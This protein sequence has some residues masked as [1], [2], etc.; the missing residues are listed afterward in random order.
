[1]SELS[2]DDRIKLQR[3]CV[4]EHIGSENEGNWPAVY[5]TFVDSGHA[6]YDVMPLST[7]FFGRD[8]VQ[9]FYEYLQSALPDIHFDVTAEYDVPGCSIREITAAGTHGGEYCGLAPTNRHGTVEIVVFFLF[10]DGDPGRLVAE[11]VYFDNE[12][13]LR[14]LRGEPDA[15]TGVGLAGRAGAAPAPPAG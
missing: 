4:E 8:G 5:D 6:F 12:T 14:Q 1:M 9:G 11:R 10:D 3:Q 7:T 13:L 2:A 15:P